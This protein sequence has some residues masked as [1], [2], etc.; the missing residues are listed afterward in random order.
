MHDL[1]RIVHSTHDVNPLLAVEY[2]TCV[3]SS[4]PDST[5]LIPR[6]AHPWHESV[7]P[8]GL[9]GR[10]DPQSSCSRRRF[11]YDVGEVTLYRIRQDLHWVLSAV[12]PIGL[13]FSI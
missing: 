5:L 11:V 8:K 13:D 6:L 12:Q 4:A 7:F 2:L 9:D 3:L 10:L 1:G